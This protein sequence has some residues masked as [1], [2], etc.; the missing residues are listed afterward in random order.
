MNKQLFTFNGMTEVRTRYKESGKTD[1][2]FAAELSEKYDEKYSYAHIRQYRQALGIPGNSPDSQELEKAKELL[3][4]VSNEVDNELIE[5]IQ[6]F[7]A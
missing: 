4:R 3:R 5:E 6:E 7:L 2:D 1:K